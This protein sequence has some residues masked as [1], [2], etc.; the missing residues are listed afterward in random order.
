[1]LKLKLIM[2]D[3][4]IIGRNTIKNIL[5]NDP[6]YEIVADFSDGRSALNWL[7]KNDADIM[8]C[9]MQMPEMTGVELIR[10]VHA[11]K[12]SLPVIAISGFDDFAYVR[13]SLLNGAEDYLLKHELTLEGIR[14]VLGRVRE[15]YQ[16][17]PKET[18]FCR[19]TGYC[20][21]DKKSYQAE[22]IR[23][24]DKLGKIDFTPYNIVPLVVSPDYRLNETT[25]PKEYKQGI[26]SA[27]IDLM[28][29]ILGQSVP[30]L[31][32]VTMDQ[33]LVIL[34]SFSELR[35]NLY[36][37][38]RMNILT[39]RLQRQILRLLDITCTIVV[40]DVYLNLEKAIEASLVMEKLAEDK[41][42][43]GG[44]RTLYHAVNQRLE[45]TQEEIPLRLMKQLFFELENEVIGSEETLMELLD[46][47][48]D[49]RYR[50]EQIVQITEQIIDLLW[51]R[52]TAKKIHMKNRIAEYEIFSDF[53]KEILE[54]FHQTTA[55]SGE[56][57]NRYSAT[58]LSVIEYIERHYRDDISLEECASEQNISYTYLSRIFKQETG[59]RFVEYLNYC[60]INKS[61][62]LLIRNVLS[63]K[64]I[65]ERVGFRN[66]NYFF[67]V[68]KESEGITPS[69]YAS[70]N[71]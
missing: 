29:Q 34:L 20:I 36:I 43:L 53:R 16:I 25:S 10:M 28:A 12:K 3:D 8:L 63:M 6:E 9:D 48:E 54:L 22:Q 14:Q 1:M 47:L 64:E 7:Q 11:I 2:V 32:Y 21:Y 4:E 13:G 23:T 46:L 39:G 41:L 42:Y 45:Y 38:N 60:R 30:Y 37:V 61:K 51:K 67:K 71:T 65:Q 26:V 68:F 58:V 27:I 15:K 18:T 70:R 50:K 35:S 52:E 59:Y 44:D 49:R 24:L 56:K 66:Y 33:H 17:V 57:R 55:R 40:G 5:K 31:I 62:S 19:R 69:E